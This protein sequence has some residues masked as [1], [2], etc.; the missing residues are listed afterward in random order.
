MLPPVGH[1][2]GLLLIGELANSGELADFHGKLFAVEVRQ[3]QVEFHVEGSTV[4]W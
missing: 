2:R 3:F 4:N 1:S